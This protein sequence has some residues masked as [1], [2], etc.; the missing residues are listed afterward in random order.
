MGSGL[1]LEI[2]FVTAYYKTLITFM[3]GK[4]S[5]ICYK[6]NVLLTQLQKHFYMS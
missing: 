5:K 6:I 3:H 2:H 1:T 4:I